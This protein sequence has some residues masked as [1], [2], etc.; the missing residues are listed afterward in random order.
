MKCC[1]RG[2]CVCDVYIH[3]SEAK[4]ETPKR[5]SG[6][7]IATTAQISAYQK[8]HEGRRISIPRLGDWSKIFPIL[9]S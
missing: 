5:V 8:Y 2:V 7:K 6:L 9:L 1:V 4:C 3:R